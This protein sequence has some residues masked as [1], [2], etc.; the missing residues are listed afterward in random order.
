MR[1]TTRNFTPSK[2]PA[3]SRLRCSTD[4]GAR[5]KTCQDSET[6]ATTSALLTPPASAVP[7]PE[8]SA[9]RALSSTCEN[10]RLTPTA[11]SSG[12]AS[13]FTLPLELAWAKLGVQHALHKQLKLKAELAPL[14]T[15][16]KGGHEFHELNENRLAVPRNS[17]IT[18]ISAYTLCDQRNSS[19]S[20]N[21]WPVFPA[22]GSRQGYSSITR[23]LSAAS[24]DFRTISVTR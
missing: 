18:L 15:K 16:R 24:R 3:T 7:V 11:S 22:C 4:F 19:N 12:D 5:W 23:P 21:S 2:P 14:A 17:C 13:C 6:T 10:G 9:P 20:G 1:R 8:P